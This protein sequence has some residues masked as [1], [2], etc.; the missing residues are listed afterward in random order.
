[1]SAP[2]HLTPTPTPEWGALGLFQAGDV[3]TT[4][5]GH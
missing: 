3:K 4:N 1:M 5:A 2:T